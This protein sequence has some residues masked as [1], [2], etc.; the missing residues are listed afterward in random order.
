[1]QNVYAESIVHENYVSDMIRAYGTDIRYF[2]LKN[3]YPNEFKPLLDSGQLAIQGYV[4]EWEEPVRMI[5]F[6]KWDNDSI[7]LNAHGIQPDSNLTMWLNQTD[8]AI[9]LAKKL[10]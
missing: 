2:K 4:Q 1:M 10:S 8:F 3:K 9:A 5:A 6:L 7:I